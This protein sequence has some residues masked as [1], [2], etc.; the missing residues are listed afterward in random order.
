MKGIC[1]ASFYLTCMKTSN[2]CECYALT[3]LNCC[4]NI[5]ICHF[6]GTLKK[7]GKTKQHSAKLSFLFCFLKRHC[8]ESNKAYKLWLY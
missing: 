4:K 8:E 7:K 1:F 5:V 6:L 3:E 2:F